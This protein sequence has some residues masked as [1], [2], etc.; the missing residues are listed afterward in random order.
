MSGVWELRL[1]RVFRCFQTAIEL[2]EDRGYSIR[3]PKKLVKLLEA[4]DKETNDTSSVQ[5]CVTFPWFLEHFAVGGTGDASEKCRLHY[6]KLTLVAAKEDPKAPSKELDDILVVIFSDSSTLPVKEVLEHRLLAV[7]NYAAKRLIV[8][9]QSVASQVRREVKESCGLF[10]LKTFIAEEREG[11]GSLSGLNS[12][13]S[14]GC[15]TEVFDEQQLMFNPS[16][17]ETVPRHVILSAEETLE[18]LARH[19]V[20]LH[21]LPRISESDPMVQYIGATRGS[22]IKVFRQSKDS[23]PY[24]MYRQVI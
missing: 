16:H 13:K 21:Q 20:E 10:L 7:S 5:S 17:H 1:M 2:C 11:M 4:R 23:G 15:Y 8:V 3:E 19:Q 24:E 22:V 14:V 12:E 18:V 9:A 6:T